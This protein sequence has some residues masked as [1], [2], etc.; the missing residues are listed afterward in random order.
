M[1]TRSQEQTS[2]PRTY[3]EGQRVYCHTCGSEV[4]VIV[5]CTGASSGQV[6]RCCG[7]EMTPEVGTSVHLDSES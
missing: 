1:F 7:Q 6:L 5:P 3:K 2:K 4:E